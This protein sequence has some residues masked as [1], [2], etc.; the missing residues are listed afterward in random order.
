MFKVAQRYIAYNFLPP[1]LASCI[2]FVMFLLTFQLF[3]ITRII[4]NKGV[5]FS[6]I[7]E[8]IG[9][10]AISFFPMAIPLSAL[11]ATIY[12]LN[13]LCEDSEI[14]A[15][16]SFGMSKFQLFQPLLILGILISIPRYFSSKF[17]D[18]RIALTKAKPLPLP[19][20]EPS[21]ILT[22]GVSNS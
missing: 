10:I 21:P 17:S 2:F 20:R 18:E 7:L 16:R 1:F 12:T 19:P 15:M 9:H 14:M 11:V 22:K 3:K 4:I 13:K 8:L 5:E 6:V